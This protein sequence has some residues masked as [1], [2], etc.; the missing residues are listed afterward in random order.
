MGCNDIGI[1]KLEFVANTQFLSLNVYHSIVMCVIINVHCS[2]GDGVLSRKSTRIKNVTVNTFL[3]SVRLNYLSLKQF[4]PSGWKD[5]CMRK[6]E[7]IP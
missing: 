1:R 3:N 7:L 4:T 6:F 2:L 5:I